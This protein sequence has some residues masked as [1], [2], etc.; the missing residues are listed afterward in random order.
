MVYEHYHRKFVENG[1]MSGGAGYVLSKE[2]LKRLVEIGLEDKTGKFCRKDQNGP[3]DLEIG[4][5]MQKLNVTAGDSRD[6]LGR[7]RF[8]PLLPAPF[9]L[10]GILGPDSWLFKYMMYPFQ[11]VRI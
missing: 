11:T 7:G 9:L 6:N 3:E 1:Y 4:K 2:S 5:C 8:F 10:P